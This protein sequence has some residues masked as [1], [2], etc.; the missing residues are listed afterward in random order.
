MNPKA[1]K[2]PRL[3][4]DVDERRE[5]ILESASRVYAGASYSDVSVAQVAEAAGASPALVFHYFGNKAGLY[6]AVVER[7]IS[8]LQAAQLAADEA[9]PDGTSARD[10]VRVSLLTYLDHVASHP[11]SWSAPLLGGQEPAAALAVRA[12]A[13]AQYVELLR[14]V[15]QP[16]AWNRAEFA[17]AGFFGFVDA[18]CLGW[19]EAGCPEDQRHDL[20]ITAL[21]ALEGALGD[22]GR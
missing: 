6:A 17:L 13:R 18:A 20:V 1:D 11:L 4:L 16:P 7:A 15:I 2:A 19:V 22:W 21:G 14:S 10:R 12:A 8:R 9:L 3:R 5:R